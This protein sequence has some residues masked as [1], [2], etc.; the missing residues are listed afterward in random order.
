MSNI[1]FSNKLNT[2]SGNAFSNCLNLK[3]VELPD[4]VREFRSEVFRGCS[5]LEQ[6]SIP[7][8][9]ISLG[10]KTFTGCTSLQSITLPSAIT[11][12]SNAVFKNCKSLI[13]ITIPDNVM[14]IG[15][16]AF[17]GCSSLTSV[18]I[19]DTVTEIQMY[20]FS[21]CLSLKN[22]KLSEGLISIGTKAFESCVNLTEIKIPS[23]I[24]EIE[25]RV[26]YDCNN[27][28]KVSIPENVKSIGKYA[29][30]N[31]RISKILIPDSVSVINEFAF[32]N[33]LEDCIVEINGDSSMLTTVGKNAFSS[34]KKS[35]FIINGDDTFLKVLFSPY[36]ETY[37]SYDDYCEKSGH[38]LG[39]PVFNWSE[40]KKSCT[41]TFTCQ[42]ENSHIVTYNAKVRSVVKQVATC[43]TKGITRYMATYEDFI[44]IMDIEDIPKSNVHKWDSGIV[45]KKATTDHEGKK[46]FKCTICKKTKEEKIPKLARIKKSQK[47]KVTTSKNISVKKVKKKAQ[48]FKLSAKSTS[49]NKVKYRLVKNNKNIKFAAS[50]GKV[51]VKK[52]TKKGTY[53]F[54]VKMTVSGN[55]NY[56]AYSI[57]KTITIKVK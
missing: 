20:A 9:L 5:A 12:I 21:G 23:G 46:Q 51:T 15:L 2:I 29:F 56:K 55:K 37:I 27:L 19:S 13:N 26:F 3:C 53:K 1:A 33:N 14:K 28:R 6:I 49:G 57:T 48:S 43:A 25:P 7:N 22:I 40:D 24:T 36:G 47:I 8:E 10:D 52:G 4:S 17:S 38:K 54:K 18:N 30:A 39:D 34:D 41:V 50:S 16:E 31:C 11:E 44:D 32:Y 35:S 42:N 45:I